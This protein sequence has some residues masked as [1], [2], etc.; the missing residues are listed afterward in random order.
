MPRI[1]RYESS[2][3]YN[4]LDPEEDRLR[5][6]A[7]SSD[8]NFIVVGTGESSNPD[9]GCIYLFNRS[10]SI[11]LWNYS[12][13]TNVNSVDISSNGD[14]IVAGGLDNQVYLF[15][16]SSSIPLWNFS[17]GTGI[18][19]VAITQD[20]KL[21]VASGGYTPKVWLFHRSSSTPLWNYTYFST[22]YNN[23]VRISS[24]GSF[25]V[26]AFDYFIALFVRSNSTPVWQY[27]TGA[28]SGA[29][30]F[31]SSLDMNSIGNYFVV[32]S[33]NH[34][35]YRFNVAN[36]TPIWKYTT[37]GEINSVAI[38]SDGNYVI[39][40]GNDRHLYFF[41]AS[42]PTPFKYIK[43]TYSVNSIAISDDFNYISAGDSSGLIY[44]VNT[45]NDWSLSRIIPLEKNIRDLSM[46]ANGTYFVV[47][48]D[49]KVQLF[50]DDNV[51]S[52]NYPWSNAPDDLKILQNEYDTINWTLHDDSIKHP[53]IQ[54]FTII[55]S[56]D[57]YF[58][59]IFNTSQYFDNYFS[60]LNETGLV[61]PLFYESF[62]VVY[63]DGY[64][65]LHNLY[66]QYYDINFDNKILTL[67]T[68]KDQYGYDSNPI[69]AHNSFDGFYLAF[70]ADN[71]YR[72]YKNKTV[73]I[74][75]D[76]WEINTSL[77]IPMDSSKSG[78]YN[79]TIEYFDCQL[80]FGFN[81]S[82]VVTIDSIPNNN[83][84]EE[85]GIWSFNPFIVLGVL[86]LL[87]V[88]IIKRIKTH[89]IKIKNI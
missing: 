60:I 37:G 46:S 84:I 11:P 9:V 53:L 38:S 52:D 81:D 79:Y 19:S 36:A 28:E 33:K 86:S 6:V 55:Y 50:G 34:K 26:A 57:N 73:W 2:W 15:N 62:K 69:T 49:K 70:L 25:I 82:V 66:E 89:L 35:I 39:A 31:I 23:R 74:Q 21:I 41:N 88:L 77:N 83:P 18:D 5:S 63:V 80:Q 12:I 56:N 47:G 30:Q 48:V 75:W 68:D 40:G 45:T 61:N 17:A 27:S 85:F 54:C 29:Q 58:E 72:V 24:D 32:G 3:S 20:G 87:M 7:I 67:W 42:N 78:I 8:G 43:T 22:S 13:G 1:S 16:K 14:Y 10:S 76:K 71:L 64:G 44:L 51:Y 65:K 59:F 4:I